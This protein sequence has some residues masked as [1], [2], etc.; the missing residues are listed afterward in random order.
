MHYANR[1]CEL[2]SGGKAIA[3]VGV[4]YQA[5]GEWAGNYK[6]M[7][8][9][10]K[11]LCGA[12]IDFEILPMEAILHPEKFD[13]TIENQCLYLNGSEY[14]CIV[15]PYAEKLPAEFL[16]FAI[17]R[18][19][20]VLFAGGLP[21]GTSCA[22]PEDEAVTG[23]IREQFT[24]LD[25]RGLKKAIYDLG[26]KEIFLK[27]D[28][29][30]LVYRHYRKDGDCFMFFNESPDQTFEGYIKL[31]I[32]KGAVYFDVLEKKLYRIPVMRRGA[33]TLIRLELPPYA[34]CVI[35]DEDPEDLP[36]YHGWSAIL[37]KCRTMDLSGGWNCAKATA[38]S[39]PEFEELGAAEQLIPYSEIE[40][41]F[42][43][44]LSYEK[45]ICLDRTYRKAYIGFE[46]AGEL[47]DLWINGEYVD[48][49]L[50]PPYLFDV[51]GYL[52]AGK[53]L[54]RA[55][56]VTTADREQLKFPEP[57]ISMDYLVMEAT[58]I[59]GAVTLYL[60]K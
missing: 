47:V 1:M 36:D 13:G 17:R 20:P 54:I 57:F 37:S 50:Q 30:D 12:Q 18:E 58:G 5:E 32:H 23:K 24:A 41:D 31:P 39:Y 29:P 10:T 9:V 42:S 43:G 60:Q 15:V 45:E 55:E 28:F 25:I 51:S 22:D 40:E 46:K 26:G 8:D 44:F 53:N 21:E 6:K 16:A 4:L 49:R 56:A 2:L 19:V 14:K 11:A 59:Y 52:Q 38:K 33:S 7:Q 27:T 48:M 34:S 3:P 35:L